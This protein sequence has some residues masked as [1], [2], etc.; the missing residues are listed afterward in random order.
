MRRVG[1]TITGLVQGVGFRASTEAEATRLRLTGWVRNLPDGSVQAEAEGE[2][3]VVQAFL[4]WCGKG[5]ASARV[6]HLR[7]TELA[8]EGGT[9]FEIR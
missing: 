3:D 6:D 7:V 4:D 9:G 8:P 1:R 2:P 5:P